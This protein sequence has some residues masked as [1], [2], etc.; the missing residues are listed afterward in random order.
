MKILDKRKQQGFTVIELI[1][2]LVVIGILA[3]LIVFSYNGVRSRDRDALRQSDID[4]LQSQLEVFYAENSRYPTLSQLN[5]SEWLAE[6]MPDLNLETIKDPSWTDTTGCTNQNGEPKLAESPTV[7]C[8]AYNPTSAAGEAC[9]NNK[10]P[11]AHYTLTAS[12]E[13]EEEY[14]KTSLN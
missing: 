1:V 8:Y 12:L 4:T 2:V 13:T 7:N 3:S 9:D 14:I 10:A 11:C 5:N 6:N